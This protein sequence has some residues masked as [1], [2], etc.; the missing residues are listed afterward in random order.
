M[1]IIVRLA[2]LVAGVIISFE[3][4]RGS[5]FMFGLTSMRRE[6][7]DVS[8]A[9]KALIVLD[10]SAAGEERFWASDDDVLALAPDKALAADVN[11]RQIDKDSD[12]KADE[13]VL[14]VS[15][16]PNGMSPVGFRGVFEFTYKLS[17]AVDMD[18]RGVI[19]V[20]QVAGIEGSGFEAL[21]DVR[22]VQEQ[23]LEDGQKRDEFNSPVLNFGKANTSL[24]TTNEVRMERILDDYL[25]RNET[26]ALGN[27]HKVWIPGKALESFDANIRMRIPE[28]EQI[29]VTPRLE[30]TLRIVW[31]QFVAVFAVFFVIFTAFERFLFH[32]GLLGHRSVP[33]VASRKPHLS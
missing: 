4:A 19:Y 24:S 6:K 9:H 30:A 33:D 7:P 21:G 10:G 22:L 31:T 13:I 14:S 16:K 26:I 3:V 17:D 23:A 18:M 27:E 15:A 28:G 8:F 2:L 25:E 1:A 12:G 11:A 20:Q 32:F 5:G 29:L